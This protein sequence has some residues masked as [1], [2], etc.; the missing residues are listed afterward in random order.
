MTLGVDWT[1][2]SP[3]FFIINKKN[4]YFILKFCITLLEAFAT[5]PSFGSR[6]I[7]RDLCFQASWIK[8]F[9]KPMGELHRGPGREGLGLVQ[10]LPPNI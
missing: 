8:H 9:P 7:L 3:A 10:I 4:Y 2:R 5:Y 1:I 6:S